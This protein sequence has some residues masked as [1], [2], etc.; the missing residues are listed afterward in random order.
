MNL[1]RITSFLFASLCFCTALPAED[2][3]A[4]LN[5]VRS[6]IGAE[7][8]LDDLRSIHYFG[9]INSEETS[10]SGAVTK[11][12]IPV[13]IIFQKPFQQLQI[14]KHPA[15]NV[16]ITT[17][18][19][20]SEAWISQQSTTENGKRAMRILPN[21]QMRSMRSSTWENLYFFKGLE[22]LGGRVV[23]HGVEEIDGVKCRKIAFVHDS[24][25]TFT[26]YFDTQTGKLVQS[27][28][29]AGDIIREEGE[30]RVDGVRFPQKIT[31]RKKLPDGKENYVVITFE[32]IVLNET[33]PSERF[34]APLIP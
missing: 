34:A 3:S 30:L 26:R 11:V 25:N 17:A 5:K 23:D 13:E 28:T 21:A 9:A 29:D 19:D 32:K 20:G 2:I 8:T 24:K 16:V 1:A 14:L 4:F 7:A 15:K 18:L 6:Q 33:F 27:V 22:A 12:S 31:T 10:E